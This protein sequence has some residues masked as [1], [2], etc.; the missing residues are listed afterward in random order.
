MRTQSAEG[1]FSE[2]LLIFHVLVLNFSKGDRQL[3]LLA[4]K[5]IINLPRGTSPMLP[6]WLTATRQRSAEEKH[7]RMQTTGPNSHADA[8]TRARTPGDHMSNVL[9]PLALPM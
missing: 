9:L 2:S 4:R 5:A 8:R 3:V 7:F 6:L 1:G